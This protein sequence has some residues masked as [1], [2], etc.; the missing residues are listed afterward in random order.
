MLFSNQVFEETFGEPDDAKRGLLGS[1]EVLDEGGEV[2]PFEATPPLRA[3]RG[4]SYAMRFAISGEGGT[5]RRF[6]AK[7]R[8]IESDGVTGGLLIIREVTD[9]PG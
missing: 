2:L 7:I 6:E 9:E 8:A 1:T 5:L 4:E 3:A